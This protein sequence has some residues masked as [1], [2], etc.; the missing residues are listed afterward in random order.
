VSDLTL[1]I[2]KKRI[3]NS[4]L[5]FLD[6]GGGV[7]NVFQKIWQQNA[8]NMN[9]MIRGSQ[10]MSENQMVGE[11]SPC[12]IKFP[13]NGI[14]SQLSYGNQFGFKPGTAIGKRSVLILKL[15]I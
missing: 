7:G 12:I 2:I 15:C 6:Q 9:Q 1:A 14:T 13:G 3:C 5:L 8:N 11:F 4:H 10:L